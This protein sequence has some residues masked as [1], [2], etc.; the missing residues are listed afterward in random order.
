MHGN[1][2][3]HSIY[4]S[5]LGLVCKPF[6]NV[7][8]VYKLAVRMNTIG[9]PK[10]KTIVQYKRSLGGRSESTFYCIHICTGIPL[11]YECTI[12]SKMS[13]K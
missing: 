12:L 1:K 5:Q 2:T 9:L 4:F 3:N 10:H 6:G 8:T 13:H 7:C 11:V